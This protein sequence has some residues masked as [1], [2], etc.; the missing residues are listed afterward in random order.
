L[1]AL[2]FVPV[3][4]EAITAVRTSVRAAKVAKEVSMLDKAVD[5]AQVVGCVAGV[6]GVVAT[7]GTVGY[8]M[9]ANSFA[10]G[11]PVLMADGSAKPIDTVQ[12]HDTVVATDPSTETTT[13][14][15]VT[16]THVHVDDDL[17]DLAVT[18][19]DG[20]TSVIHTTAGHPFWNPT[21]QDWTPAGKLAA[22]DE[23]YTP[24]GRRS[25]VLAVTS[26]AGDELMVNLTVA[27]I[28]TYYVLAGNTPVL[29]HN[30]NAGS[31]ARGDACSCTPDTDF[32]RRG[33]SWE[34]TG[35]L[36]NQAGAA[37]AA[38]FPHGVSVTTPESN[39]RLST[40][41]LDAVMATK[42]QI[43]G[44]GFSLVFTPTR[45][46]PNHHTLALPKPVTSGVAGIFNRLFGRRR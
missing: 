43:E 25:T 29:V 28:H 12:P 1:T 19:P 30:C 4:G 39:A 13:T 14:A 32:V 20:A 21:R 31:A 22:G 10:S 2:S 8:G 3:A 23:L 17:A 27:D 5:V 45:N 44:D 40:N 37:E 34:S 7:A 33:T 26:D 15:V 11:T 42:E 16:A 9:L 24:D 38:G 35:R 41:P 36:E 6:A 46:D 18:G